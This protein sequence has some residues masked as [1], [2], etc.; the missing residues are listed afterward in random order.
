[1]VPIEGA[2]HNNL[3]Q[4]AR[5]RYVPILHQFVAELVDPKLQAG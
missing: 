1:L 3:L 5:E 2:D 4:V